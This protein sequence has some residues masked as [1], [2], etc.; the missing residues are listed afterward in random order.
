MDLK[1]KRVIAEW[2]VC[3]VFLEELVLRVILEEM[4][5]KDLEV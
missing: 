5:V 2:K 3:L 4:A 1:V